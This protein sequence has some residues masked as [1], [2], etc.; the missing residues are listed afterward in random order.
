MK[1]ASWNIRGLGAGEK[2][3]TVK[4]LIREENIELMGLVETKHSDISIWTIRKLWG[5]HNVDWVH[6]PAVNGSGGLLVSWHNEYFQVGS[7][8]I[9]QRWICVFGKFISEAF[10][11]AVC[12]VYAPN[13]QSD[14]LELWN[15]LREFNQHLSIPLLL[16]GDF[17]EVLNVAERRN[18]SQT[19]VGMRNFGDMIQEMQLVDLDISQQFTW[20]RGKAASRLDRIMVSKE[21]VENFQN[22]KVVCKERMLSDHFPLILATSDIKWGPSPF[23]T[24]DGWLEEP[25]FLQ[26]F[27]KEWIQLSQLPFE[28]KIKAMKKPLKTWNREVFGKIDFKI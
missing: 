4:R 7:S 15:N 26:V 16:M 6:S 27:K 11:C 25:K 21:F 3:S 24:L 23:R 18:A 13:S 8:L 2:K 9:T 28:Q 12:V 10:S 5:N 1:V 19:T 20:M 17:N 14:R 22:L